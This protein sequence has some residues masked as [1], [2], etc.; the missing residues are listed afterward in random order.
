[1]SFQRLGAGRTLFAGEAL[2]SGHETLRIWFVS[3]VAGESIGRPITWILR[4]TEDWGVSFVDPDGGAQPVEANLSVGLK[5]EPH[6][7]LPSHITEVAANGV[8]LQCQ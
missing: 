6:A 5:I 3:N 2:A 4:Y 8:R 7:H 1:M